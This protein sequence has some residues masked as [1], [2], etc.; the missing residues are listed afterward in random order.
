M[1]TSANTG[2]QNIAAEARSYT[3]YILLLRQFIGCHFTQPE[4]TRFHGSLT[5]AEFQRLLPAPDLW[6]MLHRVGNFP[7]N[8]APADA[9]A[10]FTLRAAASIAARLCCCVTVNLHQNWLFQ[11]TTPDRASL[12]SRN[13][14]A[15]DAVPPRRRKPRKIWPAPSI[16]HTDTPFS[17]AVGSEKEKKIDTEGGMTPRRISCSRRQPVPRTA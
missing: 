15:S 10:P 3:R 14:G 8:P 4:I 1:Q 12:E 7:V 16:P 11:S 2:S 9:P 5:L 6:S 17:G 13:A